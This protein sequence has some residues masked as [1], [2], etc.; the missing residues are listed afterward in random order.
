MPTRVGRAPESPRRLREVSSIGQS[1][2]G[3]NRSWIAL[4]G[5]EPEPIARGRLT[6][7]PLHPSPQYPPWRTTSMRTSYLVF[8]ATHYETSFPNS[9]DAV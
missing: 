5:L 9:R 4:A 6:Q 2:V 7:P 1:R 3:A 8:A